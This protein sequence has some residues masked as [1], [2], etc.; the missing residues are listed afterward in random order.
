MELNP[1]QQLLARRY[2]CAESVL[3]AVCREL[4]VENALIP[5]IA[6]AF[7]GGM[8]RSGEVCGAVTGALMAIGVKRGREEPE[9]SVTE[10]NALARRFLQG[11]REQMGSIYCR[12]L[13]GK[14]L[15][16]PEGL[17]QYRASDVPMRVC[18]PAVGFA[19]QTTLDLLAPS[20]Q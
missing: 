9:Q 5:R 7:G 3:M 16:T 20:Q 18:L 12:D 8:G 13:T 6:T 10:I 2:H 11:F 15:S 4:G 19:Y 14:D 1:A 17:Q